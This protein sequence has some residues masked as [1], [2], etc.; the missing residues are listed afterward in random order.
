ESAVPLLQRGRDQLCR[1][2]EVLVARSVILERSFDVLRREL[3]VTRLPE[4]LQE[5]RRPG[6]PAAEEVLECGDRRPLCGWT[7][8]AR[9]GR[10]CGPLIGFRDRL[11]NVLSRTIQC[12]AAPSS[13]RS[14]QRPKTP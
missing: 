8:P 5:C 1:P 9:F 13:A 3:P 11:W 6:S 2:A 7:T 4:V 10:R 14:A 12:Q